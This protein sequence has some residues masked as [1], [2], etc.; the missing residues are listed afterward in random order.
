MMKNLMKFPTYVFL[1]F[2]SL[3]VVSCDE[4]DDAGDVGLTNSAYDLTKSNPNFSS[5]AAAI[6]RADLVSILD[7]P[8]TYTVFAPTNTAFSEFLQDNGFAN[9]EAVPVDVLRAT[10]LYHVLGSEVRSTGLADGYVKT[11]S[12][13]ADGD[14]YDAYVDVDTEV[15]IN[16]AEVDL[17]LVDI[18][19]DNGVV[20]VIDEVLTLP[21]IADLAVYNPNL[22]SLVAALSQ[23]ELVGVVDNASATLTVF[24]PLNSSF[25]AL[26][27]EDPLNAGWT[28]INDILALG[29]AGATATSTLDGVLTYHVLTTG[30]VRAGAITDG[31]TPTTAQGSTFTINTTNGVTITDTN[32]RVLN[33]IATDITAVNG[34]VHAISNVLLP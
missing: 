31:I 23:E 33:V 4:D 34:V 8:G 1:A 3:A 19:V 13:N 20:H 25:D 2:L 30:A 10:L 16:D 28:D 18:D 7:T 26:I 24:A 14:A 29:D 21:T 11:A 9:L 6:E 17:T 32:G 27:T 12:T 5:L 15:F 22:S